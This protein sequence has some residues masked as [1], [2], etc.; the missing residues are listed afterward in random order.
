MAESTFIIRL[1]QVPS[2]VAALN[3]DIMFIICRGC[4]LKPLYLKKSPGKL[5]RESGWYRENIL[6]PFIGV[7]VFYF[8]TVSN[9]RR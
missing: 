4:R 1:A 7:E 5:I 2:E 8:V 9:E 3:G 6:R